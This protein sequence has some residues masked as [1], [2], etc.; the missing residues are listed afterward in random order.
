MNLKSN[1]N[2]KP[3]TAD[4]SQEKESKHMTSAN[5]S[6]GSKTTNP[7]KNESLPLSF[8]KRWRWVC[9]TATLLVVASCI[10]MAQ[11][12]GSIRTKTFT[13]NGI[14][15]EMISVA[16]GT[17]DMGSNDPEACE[18][19]RIIKKEEIEDFLIGQT[20]VTQELWEAVMG[21][22]P[23]SFVGSK[24]PVEC[25]SWNDCQEFLVKLNELTGLKFRLPTE[26]EWEYA[27]RGGKRSKGYRFS[28]SDEIGDVACWE[29]NSEN[30]TFA[31][32]SKEPNELGIYDM[33]G[34][35]WELTCDRW[36]A[37]YASPR[38]GLRIVCRG[39]GWFNYSRHCRSTYRDNTNP[40]FRYNYLGLRLAM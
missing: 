21:N 26:A 6:S 35:V 11:D 36:S 12:F 37:D 18:D 28:G 24:N 13:V 4:A 10:Y 1:F 23:S 15:F 30:K 5:K 25:V 29:N 14:S 3:A 22:N 2:S 17:F 19:E 7:S 38:I 32:A 8:V 9:F 16:G 40:S 39:G 31:V 33:T 27:A 20:E 34:N